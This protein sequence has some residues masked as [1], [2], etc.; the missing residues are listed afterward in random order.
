MPYL[1][2]LASLALIAVSAAAWAEA[3]TPVPAHAEGHTN[4]G[5]RAARA[6]TK[7]APAGHG[8][9]PPTGGARAIQ[10]P[11]GTAPSLA[12]RSRPAPPVS[13]N[14][15]AP[16]AVPLAATSA[17]RNLPARLGGPAAYDPKRSAVLG[18]TLMRPK[19]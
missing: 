17:H 1:A 3:A 2:R 16:P 18:S 5:A 9:A 11:L 14:P 4:L 8:G 6:P 19:R 7:A 15:H 12:A 13:R 10:R